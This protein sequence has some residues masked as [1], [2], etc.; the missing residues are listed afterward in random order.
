MAFLSLRA[1]E[2]LSQMLASHGSVHRP[3][4]ILLLDQWL[5]IRDVSLTDRRVNVG[6]RAIESAQHLRG[7]SILR[8]QLLLILDE[9]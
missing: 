4:R 2:V 3:L 5:L 7:G 8:A 6:M 1:G 9:I